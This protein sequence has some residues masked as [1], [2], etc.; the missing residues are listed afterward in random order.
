MGPLKIHHLIHIV[1]VLIVNIAEFVWIHTLRKISS[2]SIK[3][4]IFYFLV[5]I[6]L[7]LCSFLFNRFLPVASETSLYFCH[8][9][10]FTLSTLEMNVLSIFH[11]SYHC[12]LYPEILQS[13]PPVA[14]VNTPCCAIANWSC[15]SLFSW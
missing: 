1:L 13:S 10:L 7:F 4:S 2:Y 6:K 5:A 12:L 14:V 3:K 15:K 11:T 8:D 9:T